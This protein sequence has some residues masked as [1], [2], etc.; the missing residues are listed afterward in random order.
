MSC[1]VLSARR[2]R[3]AMAVMLTGILGGC[4]GGSST[5]PVAPIRISGSVGDGP[6][7]DA[8]I[9]VFDA[10]GTEVARG[11][12]FS[13]SRYQIAVPAGAR[14]PLRVVATGGRDLVT[15]RPVEFELMSMVTDTGAQTVNLSPISS[16]I[17]HAAKCSGVVGARS[18]A[19]AWEHVE[20]TLSMGLDGTRIDHPVSSNVD[21]SNVATVLLANEALGE[22]IRRVHTVM[23]S[24]GYV[25]THDQL[26][27]KLACDLADG[28]LDGRGRNA[29]ARL[30]STFRAVEV[31]VLLETIAGRLEVDGQDA[32]ALLDAAIRTILPAATDVSVESVVPTEAMVQQTRRAIAVLQ[33]T[34]DND[35]LQN[36][37]IALDTAD[38]TT[39]RSSVDSLLTPETQ[40]T[41]ETVKD[42]V[43]LSDVA[44]I[45]SLQ[46][47]M[48]QQASVPVPVVSFRATSE[49]VD[50]G[51]TVLLS[52]ASADADTCL[53]SEGWTGDR[54]A[55]GS[56]RTPVLSSS[57]RFT[58]SC[59]GL[60]GTVRRSVV[61][62]VHGQAVAIAATPV[63]SPKKPP[64]SVT[65]ALVTPAS[66]A[67]PVPV[68]PTRVTTPL[69]TV[70]PVATPRVT[71]AT[72]TPETPTPMAPPPATP[73]PVPAVPVVTLTAD[74]RTI[75]A[76]ETV[77]L[78][79]TSRNAASCEA[80]R[81]WQGA[82]PTN[83]S[84]LSTPLSA[85]T[86]FGL[87]CTGA[88]GSAVALVTVPVTSVKGLAL[89]WSKPD[90]NEDG[91]PVSLVGYRVYYGQQSGQYS[92]HR[93]IVDP[94]ATS[95][96][97]EVVPGTYYLVMTAVD[98][99]GQESEHSEELQKVVN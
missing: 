9:T 81:G 69:V 16:L 14:L 33:G 22:A 95:V 18:L 19:S 67:T 78:S 70:R 94:G 71:P 15:G 51:S 28:Q 74:R 60:G 43:A 3:L 8:N 31:E 63:P 59:A 83:G 50:S 54:P 82:L 92:N 34:F 45:A 4:G 86:S 99:D 5:A 47:R 20:S 25:M 1:T 76:G 41:I 68:T 72:V 91:T 62:N 12:A 55:N 13:T 11:T 46:A 24:A 27:E 89:S 97:I 2:A 40:T 6:V 73:T 77:N 88:G 64:V 93:D 79:W 23:E 37:G 32:T 80:N 90:Q 52:W 65:P 58:L 17:S 85:S 30:T 57:T 38:R 44:Q 75:K 61:V 49:L 96:N 21:A 42:A 36:L 10:G 66:V 29:D 48:S 26:L 7:V 53:A 56:L 84:R 98:R 39:L 87:T 35:A